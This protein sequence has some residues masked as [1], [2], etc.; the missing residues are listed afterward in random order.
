LATL[1]DKVAP[2]L[3]TQAMASTIFRRFPAPELTSKERKAKL[4]G[5]HGIKG[6]G[7]GAA[8]DQPGSTP[9]TWASRSCG[10]TDR[11]SPRPDLAPKPTSSRFRGKCCA[12][13]R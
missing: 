13:L 2:A 7:S 4:D 9:R 10:G 11:S 12:M 8:A 5:R 3:T 1:I 6:G